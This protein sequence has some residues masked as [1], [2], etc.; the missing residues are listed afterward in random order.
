MGKST[1]IETWKELLP[2]NKGQ[3]K[4]TSQQWDWL[5]IT[6]TSDLEK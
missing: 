1:L 6:L 4:K 3:V 2:Y 5:T